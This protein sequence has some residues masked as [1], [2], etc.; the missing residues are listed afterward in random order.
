LFP[1]QSHSTKQGLLKPANRLAS[2]FDVSPTSVDVRL[3]I[4]DVLS[5]E[6]A[7]RTES[8]GNSITEGLGEV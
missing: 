8:V 7:Q 4:L 2:F 5:D 6:S 1:S 3:K